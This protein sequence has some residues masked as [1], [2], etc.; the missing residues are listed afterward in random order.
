MG[1]VWKCGG[2]LA[3]PSLGVTV[4]KILRET[5]RTFHTENIRQF[6]EDATAGVL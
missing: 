2:L 1:K 4:S 3:V 5:K 6:G